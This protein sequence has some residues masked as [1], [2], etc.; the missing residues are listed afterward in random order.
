M[1]YLS[2]LPSLQSVLQYCQPSVVDLS[3]SVHDQQEITS[4]QI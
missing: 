4:E 3:K 2:I 1:N